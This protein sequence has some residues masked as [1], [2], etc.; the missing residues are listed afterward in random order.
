VGKSIRL[1]CGF[2]CTCQLFTL[3]KAAMD[4]TTW[5]TA[6][7][8][9]ETA[10]FL[11]IFAGFGVVIYR[12]SS[13][14][15]KIA[16]GDLSSLPEPELRVTYKI[17]QA[18]GR[19]LRQRDGLKGEVPLFGQLL[20]FSIMAWLGLS[21]LQFHSFVPARFFIIFFGFGVIFYAGRI[22]TQSYDQSI[23][24]YRDG[25]ANRP[26]G[27]RT[28]Y[29]SYAKAVIEKVDFENR[30]FQVITLVP[31]SQTWLTLKDEYG[32]KEDADLT[33]LLAL[34]KEQGINV[35]ERMV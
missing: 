13:N 24:F 4:L 2:N 16:R 12:L 30:T 10:L 19:Y 20:V 33:P 18:F 35:E 8:L 7:M 5:L 1:F 17:P 21:L 3:N 11:I 25:I 27:G 32:F 6:A 34:L 28:P 31:K 15:I 9:G 14:L 29:R 22:F 26:K 23:S